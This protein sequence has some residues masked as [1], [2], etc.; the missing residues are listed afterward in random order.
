MRPLRPLRPSS[1]AARARGDVWKRPLD[2][3]PF[4]GPRSRSLERRM[5]VVK[6]PWT[7]RPLPALVRACSS[8][9]RWSEMTKRHASLSWGWRKKNTSPSTRTL[10]IPA[11]LGASDKKHKSKD[12]NPRRSGPRPRSLERR[13]VVVQGPWTRAGTTGVGLDRGPSLEEAWR[14]AVRGR[15]V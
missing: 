5:V 10:D 4:F 14:R 7:F 12:Q 9:G 15:N 13:T 3:P 2:V 11:S 1:T 6:G 8:Q